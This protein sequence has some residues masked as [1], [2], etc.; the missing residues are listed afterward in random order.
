MFKRMDRTMVKECAA[1]DNL[2]LDL[3][4]RQA[5]IRGKAVKLTKTEFG[6]LELFCSQPG[7]T[8][9]REFI[10]KQVWWDSKLYAS[11][12]ALDVHIQRLRKKIEEN[13]KIP[14]IIVTVPGDGYRFACS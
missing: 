4:T 2:E 9:T 5:I 12:R 10:E 13:P 14:A 7:K 8:L 6:I 3:N 1:F 11:S